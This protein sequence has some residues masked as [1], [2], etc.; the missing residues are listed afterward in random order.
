[1]VAVSAERCQAICHPLRERPHPLYYIVFVIII[2]VSL[3]ARKYF[4]FQSTS[5]GDY[6]TTSIMEYPTYIMF[7]TIWQ[8][9]ILT[10][11]T[12][13]QIRIDGDGPTDER[14]TFITHNPG[15]IQG[16][17]NFNRSSTPKYTA[18]SG[19]KKLRKRHEKSV[20][21]LILIVFVFIVC[22]SFRLGVQVYQTF[23]SSHNIKDH[24]MYCNNQGKLHMPMIFLVLTSFN[25]LFLIINSSVNFII[26]CAVRKSFRKSF[27]KLVNIPTQCFD[28]RH[29]NNE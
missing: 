26:Y 15:V 14:S 19:Q 29:F 6:E 5:D 13:G 2:S 11:I 23:Y 22:H 25:N 24:F 28:K 8:E 12:E 4:E 10:G 16:N 9:L 1:M 3:N 21:I 18:T 7:S 27:Y 20:F 17:N